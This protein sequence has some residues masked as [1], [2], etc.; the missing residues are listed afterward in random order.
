MNFTKNIY[1]ICSNCVMDTTDSNIRF[2]DQDLCDHCL[3]F[4]VV[5]PKGHYLLIVT[6]CHRTKNQDTL[7]GNF[8]VTN[9]SA[10]VG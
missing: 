1:K 8:I 10:A 9:S 4:K 6:W 2:S 5:L 7:V 3:T